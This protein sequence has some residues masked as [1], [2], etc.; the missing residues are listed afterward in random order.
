[1]SKEIRRMGLGNRGIK[2]GIPTD[3]CLTFNEGECKGVEQ[4]TKKEFK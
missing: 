2:I 4:P 3:T 1:M